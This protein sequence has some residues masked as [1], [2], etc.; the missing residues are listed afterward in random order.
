MKTDQFFVLVEGRA[1]E[2]KSS[3]VYSDRCVER[4]KVV[5]PNWNKA[6]LLRVGLH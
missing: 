4:H 6:T 3:Q 1:I 2:V 5:L